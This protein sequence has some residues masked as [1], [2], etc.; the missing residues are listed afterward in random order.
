MDQQKGVTTTHPK[1]LE[2]VVTVWR[3][4]CPHESELPYYDDDEDAAGRTV[5]RYGKMY[6]MRRRISF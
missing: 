1:K 4:P 3:Y 5:C 2:E 6:S